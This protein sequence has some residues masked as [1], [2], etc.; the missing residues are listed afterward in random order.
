MR[1]A[2]RAALLPLL[3]LPAGFAA[4]FA[5]G[6]CRATLQRPLQP[7]CGGGRCEVHGILQ[8][9]DVDAEPEPQ[10]V[11]L[12]A[13]AACGGG[14]TDVVV[15]VSVSKAHS[16]RGVLATAAPTPTGARPPCQERASGT[17]QRVSFALAAVSSAVRDVADGVGRDASR[18]L[19]DSVAE[20]QETPA[21]E[22][23]AAAAA[24]RRVAYR[25]AAAAAAAVAGD[26]GA[27]CRG[28]TSVVSSLSPAS[29][30]CTDAASGVQY[31]YT[32]ALLAAASDTVSLFAAQP[33]G[34][35]PA[36]LQRVRQPGVAWRLRAQCSAAADEAAAG[37]LGEWAARSASVSAASVRHV[38]ALHRA[39]DSAD[40]WRCAG[41]AVRSGVAGAVA[42]FVALLAA[43]Y[44]T[45]GAHE[46][47]LNGVL[48][49]AHTAVVIALA[50]TCL[51]ILWEWPDCSAAAGTGQAAF[52]GQTIYTAFVLL[53]SALSIA[54][55]TLM[56]FV[57][58]EFA[59]D[60]AHSEQLERLWLEALETADAQTR[61][62]GSS[63]AMQR[64]HNSQ[65]ATLKQRTDAGFPLRPPFCLQPVLLCLGCCSGGC[66]AGA[67]ASYAGR[68]GGAWR[69]CWAAAAAATVVAAALVWEL[70]VKDWEAYSTPVVIAILAALHLLMLTARWLVLAAVQHTPGFKIVS[71]LLRFFY[72]FVLLC[73]VGSLEWTYPTAIALCEW[74]LLLGAR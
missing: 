19:D 46:E 41:C 37:S 34:S 44:G 4:E 54:Q 70:W 10:F 58:N 72:L 1:A 12:A 64:W 48:V 42:M 69:V 59:A 31:V 23:A 15:D 24:G 18:A 6:P 7:A 14:P 73:V 47:A 56:R 11:S 38:R 66:A 26:G 28:S 9:S 5:D 35:G 57:T 8:V 43:V 51:E 33:L 16:A 62:R 39:Q 53:S 2:M 32:A 71:A 22:L 61:N 20:L 29:A 3:L 45:V 36:A 52:E 63:E 49:V 40:T 30:P 67:L 60:K 25:V 21:Y 68:R 55:R 27:Q 17:V 50:F 13:L 65:Y 74:S